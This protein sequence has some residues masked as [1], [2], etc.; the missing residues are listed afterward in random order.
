MS[1]FLHF[2]VLGSLILSHGGNPF[3][4]NI[5]VTLAELMISNV[6]RIAGYEDL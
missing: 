2:F 3:V 6:D 4:N 1:S 5:F